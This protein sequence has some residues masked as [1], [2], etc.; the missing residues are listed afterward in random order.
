MGTNRND[1]GRFTPRQTDEDILE[2]V[3]THE[4]AATSE[5]ASEISV[6]RQAADYR[7]R[8]LLDEDR[9]SKKKIGAS[10]VWFA[11][12]DQ[13]ELEHDTRPLTDHGLDDV[14]FPKSKDRAR[15]EQAV[16]ASRDYIRDQ[17]GASM[18]E[19]VSS[20]MPDHPLG[21]DVPDLEPGDRFRGAWWRRVVKPGLESLEEIEKPSR[22]QSRWRYV[23][24]K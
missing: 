18:R 12:E 4:P 16:R 10:L 19:I 15:C 1:D 6:S 9:V 5:V 8:K 20:I 22:G 24:K 23:G 7:L 17:D 14:D 11:P 2:A 13:D 21:Y 3:R